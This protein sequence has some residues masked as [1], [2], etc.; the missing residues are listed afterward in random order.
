MITI[1]EI[2][3]TNLKNIRKKLGLTQEKFAE[4]IG[5]QT[6]SVTAIENAKFM[7]TPKNID[8]ICKKLK[9]PVSEL[10]MLPDELID[11]NKTQKIRIIH[12][13]IKN[14]NDNELNII[15]NIV[16]NAFNNY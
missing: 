12:E 7:P 2:F 4:L 3:G 1:S 10:F 16:N 13:K 14:F 5:I 6:R 11:I 9:K 15:Y 8:K